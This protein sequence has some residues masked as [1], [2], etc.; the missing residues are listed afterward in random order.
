MVVHLDNRYEYR[1]GQLL[2]QKVAAVVEA[3]HE[4]CPEIE[5]QW[6][7]QAQRKPDDAAFRLVHNPKDGMPY[8]MF[9]VKTE[10]EFD[11]RVL[12][13][14]I[15]GDQRF[16]AN[17][18]SEIEASE[19]AARRVAHQKFL[20]QLEEANEIAASVIKS[21]KDTYKVNDNLVISQTKK[22]NQAVKPKC[23]H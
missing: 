15:M 9:H 16:G 11:A 14:V 19:Q 21:N 1:E 7:P 18:V 22:G 6:I 5:V 4:Y 2:S 17:I 23:F 13:K 20:N 3:I 8:V 12:K 10:D